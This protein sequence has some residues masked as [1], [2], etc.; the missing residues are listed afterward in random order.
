MQIIIW[1]RCIALSELTAMYS[2]PRDRTIAVKMAALGLGFMEDFVC[3]TYFT[4]TLWLFDTCKHAV[5]RR[6]DSKRW[7]QGWMTKDCRKYRYI[8]S[9]MAPILRD[10]DTFHCRLGALINREMRFTFDL[11]TMAISEKEFVGAAPISAKEIQR[12]CVATTLMVVASTVFAI[13][14]EEGADTEVEASTKISRVRKTARI[15]PHLPA[16]FAGRRRYRGSRCAS[17][18]CGGVTLRSKPWVEAFI[19]PT[20]EHELFGD[21]SLYRRT[22][23]FRGDLAFDVDVSKD[24][25]PNVLVIGVGQAAGPSAIVVKYSYESLSE[26]LLFAQLMAMTLSWNPRRWRYARRKDELQKV[27]VASDLHLGKFMDRMEKEGILNDT[28]VVIVGD[29]GQAPEADVTNTHE[30]SVTRVAAPL[31]QKA[32]RKC[33]W[34]RVTRRRRAVRYSKHAGGHHGSAKGGF[35]RTALDA[36]SSVRSVSERCVFSND[37]S[38]KMSIVR[39][40]ASAL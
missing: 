19:H 9:V 35:V 1:S 21:G 20:E 26:S 24:N 40:T 6:F 22:T 25:P 30:E 29:H 28:I 2:S 17:C 15:E 27:R 31:S 23:G 14:L 3:T 8:C 13:S 18:C 39:V 38:R 37:P 5:S 16:R 36:H 11:V 33:R 7:Q 34:A 32:D 10:D 4:C 12:G